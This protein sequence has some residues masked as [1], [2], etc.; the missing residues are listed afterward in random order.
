MKVLIDLTHPAHVHF[1]NAVG[2]ELKKRG[3]QFTMTARDKDVL[4]ELLQKFMLEYKLLSKK[5]TGKF[6]LL[7]E[8]IVRQLRLLKFCIKYK[9][10]ILAAN[11]G[12]FV[13]HIGWLL[14]KPVVVW[15]D[16]EVAR[17][18][19]KITYPF[20]SSFYTPDCF[21]GNLGKKHHFYPGLH[22]LAYLHPKRFTADV[23]VVK[24]A[25]IN[26]EEKYCIIRFVS[27]Q[28]H[29]DVGQHGF[30]SGQRLTFI[31]QIAKYARPYITSEAPLPEELEH[32]RLS[33]PAHLI[34]HILA[35]AALYVGEGATM[36]TESAILG[37]P[38]VYVNTLESG[39]IKMLERY[40]L[41]KQV[42]DDNQA[43]RCCID[44]LSDHQAKEKSRAASKKLLEDK[45]DVTDY[46][47]EV[48]EHSLDI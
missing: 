44:W 30:V 2:K 28:A 13:S 37:V 8:Y 1:W 20:V 36:A 32:Y 26:P 24:K 18:L 9:P 39:N 10:D 40:G 11:G 15:D 14:R 43:L 31:S 5:G 41:V 22:E 47:V 25:G 6:G 34:H 38:A 23:E 7:K 16:T 27:W 42:T 33:I 19:H 48:I 4:V 46:V 3:H 12:L 29:H 17:F 45:I 21:E 35:F